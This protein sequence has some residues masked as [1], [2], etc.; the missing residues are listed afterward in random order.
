MGESQGERE[1][2]L[3]ERERAQSM[4][5]ERKELT[6][7]KKGGIQGGEGGQAKRAFLEVEGSMS[8]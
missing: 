2:H 5:M 7:V 3:V 1:P 4:S 6:T 8:G